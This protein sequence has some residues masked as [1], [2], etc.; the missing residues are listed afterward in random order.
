M[1]TQDHK[2]VDG[3]YGS[4]KQLDKLRNLLVEN[5]SY[6][7]GGMIADSGEY[8]IVMSQLF[9]AA[10]IRGRLDAE[11]YDQIWE[12][13]DHDL[14]MFSVLDWKKAGFEG[15]PEGWVRHRPSNRRRPDGDSTK[16]EVRP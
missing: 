7:I 2:V 15:E 1:R 11:G 5:P 9:N 8:W 3:D 10:V 16:E 6:A 14:A 4:M 13:A 12:F